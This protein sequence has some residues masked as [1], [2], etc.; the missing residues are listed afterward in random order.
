MIK[1]EMFNVV[2]L[3]GGG[4]EVAA[5]FDVL[6]TT[7]QLYFYEIMPCEIIFGRVL[8]LHVQ[9]KALQTMILSE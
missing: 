2:A 1:I 4:G 7:I 9:Q 8:R 6:V 5:P 3:F